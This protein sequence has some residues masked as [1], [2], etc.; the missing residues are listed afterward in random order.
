MARFGQAFV[1]QATNPAFAQ[2]LMQ[3]GEQIGSYGRR[4]R[5]K[6][7]IRSTQDGLFAKMNE[8]A[9]LERAGDIEGLERVQQEITGLMTGV[10]N[11]ELRD[12]IGQAA[13]DVNNAITRA[14][15]KYLQVSAR[16]LNESNASLDSIN[17]QIKA[18]E[19]D[20]LTP[21]AQQKLNSLLAQKESLE[22]VIEKL[23]S[24][25]DIS[26]EAA[27]QLFNT[28]LAA[29]TRQEQ[30]LAAKDLLAKRELMGAYGT[31]KWADVSQKYKD[32][33]QGNVVNLVQSIFDERELTRLEIKKLRD[34]S[35]ALSTEEKDLAKKYNVDLTDNPSIDRPNLIKNLAQRMDSKT[36]SV[37]REDEAMKAAEAKGFV[38]TVLEEVME[39][40]SM[41]SMWRDDL[42]DEI[43]N[44]LDDPD[45][46][47][48]KDIQSAMIGRSR[49]EAKEEVRD[50]IAKKFPTKWA[51]SE[52]KL[53]S[54]AKKAQ[55]YQ[56]VVAAITKDYQ[57]EL[58]EGLIDKMPSEGVIKREADRQIREQMG[59]FATLADMFFD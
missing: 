41:Y 44:I 56:E 39:E 3:V 34:A 25:K 22:A 11:T 40:R 1:Q 23:S 9:G 10:Q 36:K 55:N 54:R 59:T 57:K 31:P 58:D 18:I 47:L 6:E 16:K 43:R 24:N 27:D 13:V 30:L 12:T 37:L 32:S 29:A 33:D 7:E 50:I 19:N 42:E 53:A 5:E 26:I 2:G 14:Q 8:A 38:R 35:G 51:E 46:Q 4:Q 17:K 15:P 20:D 21:E 28:Q 48:L 49:N 45:N 52:A